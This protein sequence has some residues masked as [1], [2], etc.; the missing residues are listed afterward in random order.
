MKMRSAVAEGLVV[1]LARRE[2]IEDRAGDLSHF[3][4]V[5]VSILTCKVMELMD[6]VF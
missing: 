1:Q 5:S 4:E 3:G 6:T 2:G